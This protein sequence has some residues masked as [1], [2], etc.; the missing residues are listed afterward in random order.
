MFSSPKVSHS[1]YLMQTGVVP[2]SEADAED[3]RELLDYTLPAAA[4]EYL[5]KMREL[6]E[7]NG[8]ELIL[9]KAPTNSWAYWWYDE[10]EEQIK[11][12]ANEKKVAYYNFIPLAD[13]IGI[14]W[15]TDTYDEGLH[16]NVYGAEKF[17]KHL[18]ALLSEKHGIASH[19]DEAEAA[20]RWNNYLN[21]YENKKK[22]ME[23]TEK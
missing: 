20:S 4:M 17:T 2:M 8:S 1:G 21:E 23:D 12:Y 11:E 5:D 15:Q 13:E 9:V 19:K 22:Q 18:G 14:D 16:L 10:W 6:C 7:E 3:P